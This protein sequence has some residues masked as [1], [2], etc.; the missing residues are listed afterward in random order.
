MC[1]YTA[2]NERQGNLRRLVDLAKVDLIKINHTHSNS[3]G[4]VYCFYFMIYEKKVNGKK[5][6]K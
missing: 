1:D 6:E 5:I 2:V 3:K 4:K